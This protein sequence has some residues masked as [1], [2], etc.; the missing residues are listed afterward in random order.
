MIR[1]NLRL[2]GCPR[3]PLEKLLQKWP[4][5][6]WKMAYLLLVNLL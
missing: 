2:M 3:L 5:F 4:A 6:F 1:I